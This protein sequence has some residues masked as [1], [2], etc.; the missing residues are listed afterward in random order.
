MIAQAKSYGRPLLWMS[1]MILMLSLFYL[2]PLLDVIRLSFTNTSTTSP[3]FTYTLNSYAKT[4]TDS[5]FFSTA[6]VSL[7]FVFSNIIVQIPLGLMI[8]LALSTGLRKKLRG[9]IF[10]R[11]VVLAAWMAPGV[12]VGIVWQMLLAGSQY[13]IVNYLLETLGLGRVGFL[14][15]PKFALLSIIA[16]NIWRGTA[17][18]MI[19]QFAG[20]QRIPLELYEAADID[21]SSALQK[22]WYITIPQLLPILFINLVLIT[23]YTFNT[24]DMIIVLTGGGPARATQVLTLSAY[25][26]VFSFFNLGRGSAVAV[27]LLLFNL[28]MAIGYYKLVVSKAN[29]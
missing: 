6:K 28:A 18:T 8:A 29:Q 4:F 22:L 10:V 7:I 5:G 13:G 27:V 21:G 3:D 26:Q 19:L 15:Q 24:F 20:L 1:P 25:E 12:L 17:F 23:I 2:Y 14:V 16:A 11:T 9:T